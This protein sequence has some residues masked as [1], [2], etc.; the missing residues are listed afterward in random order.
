[1]PAAESQRL[2]Y[3][4][5]FQS[6]YSEAFQSWFE[7]LAHELHPVGDFQ[8]IRKT[9]GDGGLDGFVISL[10]LV[11]AVYAPARTAAT[12]DAQT[13][14]KIRSDFSKASS[15][16][17]GKFRAWVF[18]HNHRE[19]KLGQRSTTAISELT[20]ANP[21]VEITVL[22]INTLWEKLTKLPDEALKRL[23]GDGVV[24]TTQALLPLEEDIPA[25]IKGELERGNELDAAGKYSAAQDVY[26]CALRKAEAADHGRARF[27]ARIR[28]AEAIARQESDRPRAKDLLNACLAELKLNPAPD[29]R[30]QV[31]HLLGFVAIGDGRVLDA[32]SL[33]REALQGARA[34]SDRFDEGRYLTGVALAEEMLG[35]LEEAHRLLDEAADIFRVE[36]RRE[37]GDIRVRAATNLGRCYEGKAAVYHHEGKWI[38][39]LAAL[40][41]AEKWFRESNNEDNLAHILFK[42]AEALLDDF[43]WQPGLAAL[44]DAFSIFDKL[45]NTR[46]MLRCYS[47]RAH[48]AFQN[49]HR[50]EAA[51]LAVAAIQLAKKAASPR[52]QVE[53][54]GE[55]AA[56]CREYDIPGKATEYLA[57]AKQIA[58]DH[59][60]TDA[61]VRCLKS[62][63]S[64]LRGEESKAQREGLLREA[65]SHLESLLLRTEIKGRRAF[66]MNEIGGLFAVLGDLIEARSWFEHALKNYDEIGDMGGVANALG[67]LAATACEENNP[68]QAIE[69][70]EELLERANGKAFQHFQAA[71]HHDLVHLKL[72]QGDIVSSRRH[73][74]TC[75]A[76]TKQHG[77][78]DIS[79][80]LLTTRERLEQAERSRKPAGS[81]LSTLLR[82]LH[83]WKNRYP[84]VADAILPFWYWGFSADLW[85]N[86]RSMFGVKFLVRA[87]SAKI[88]KQFARNF[89]SLGDLFIYATSFPLKAIRGVDVIPTHDKLLLPARLNV[90]AFEGEAPA[91]AATKALI[92]ILDDLP[93]FFTAFSGHLQEFPDATAAI[94]GRRY[95]VPDEVLKLMFGG[96][97]E[98]LIARRIIAMPVRESEGDS[99]L[100]HDMCIAW[101]NGLIPVFFGSLP[102]PGEVDQEQEVSLSLPTKSATAAKSSVRRFISDLR[103]NPDTALARLVEELESQASCPEVATNSTLVRLTM[104]KFKAGPLSVVHP[105]LVVADK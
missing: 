83:A 32:K 51:G 54:L 29:G 7:E 53:A 89:S 97:A 74:D 3:R 42:K 28:L 15:T 31:L 85:S 39:S 76:I 103:A 40:T 70:L 93:Y 30:D 46:S 48:A 65:I 19:G 20:N 88:F 77:F 52:E 82:G 47:L 25:D 16:L 36:H 27:K 37:T 18:V 49:K 73:L 38:E 8:A 80:C 100:I 67:D 75:E 57:E 68:A 92:K 94:I 56:L 50:E 34:R 61:L 44:A 91:E 26:E 87:D 90:V 79:E 55:A 62:E 11:Y 96:N 99:A 104:L 10:Q 58:V 14:R 2:F 66:Y 22:N 63:A 17:Q 81:D 71:A 59:Q 21:L 24:D 41:E 78:H 13:A 86:C 35:N 98:R 72:S 12:G 101:E 6:L 60:L 1:M 102:P 105:A 95:R 9:Q 4:D 5:K 69:L 64:V 43:Q 33:Y 45:G 84:R 23:F